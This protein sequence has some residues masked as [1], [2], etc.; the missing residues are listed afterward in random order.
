MG[1]WSPGVGP[2]G[3]GDT[4]TGDELVDVAD[5]GDGDDV[6][7]GFGGADT[8]NGGNGNDTLYGHSA[9]ATNTI[10][11]SVFVSGLNTPV[12]AT[13]TP[14]DPGFL[15]VMEKGTGVIWRIDTAS[16]ARTTFLDIPQSEFTSDGERGALG[17]AF[18]PD[19]ATNGRFF[20]YLTD[21]QGDIQIR[22]YSRSG[23]PAVANTSWSLVTEI[24]RNPA[25]NNHN[26]G[27]IG[28]SPEDG[29]LYFAT[30]DGGGAGDPNNNAQNLDSLLGKLIRIDVD[31][32]DQFPSDPNRNYG[33]PG[34][35]PFVG[36]AGADEI[37][38]Y[39]LRNPWRITFD[40]RNGDI[41]IADVGQSAREEIDYLANGQGG[42]NFGWRIMEGN[43]PY[44]PGGPGTPQPGD[45]ILRPPVFDYPRT[46][47]TTVTGGEVYTGSNAGFVGQ[48]VF[49]DFG[50]N[51]FFTLSVVNGAAVDPTDRTSQMTG[52]LPSSVVDFVTGTDGRLY[53]I[54]I[55][56]TVWLLTPGVGAEDVADTL[57]GGAGN[58]L[59]VG[60][61][62]NDILNG[63]ADVDTARYAISSSSAS[64]HR[65]QDGSWTVTAGAEGTDTVT[66]VE[67]LD[68]TDRDVFLGSAART[69]TGDGASDLLLQNVNGGLSLWYV[70]QNGA[71]VQYANGLPTAPGWTVEGTGDL[72]G[73]G[74]DDIVFRNGA[75]G[76]MSLWQMNG[77]AISP[78]SL[79]N[80]G[81]AWSVAGIGDL[82]GDT[83]DD[84]VWRNSNGDL[85]IWFM[86]G[87]VVSGASLGNV[88]SNWVIEALGDFNGD[89]RDDMLW[90]NNSTGAASIW[91]M[92]GAAVTA[93]GFASV[94]A[95]WQVA[96][97][98][99]FNGDGRD[100]IF[101]RNASTGDV[102][103]WMMN[104][105]S[106]TSAAGFG[107]STA[108]QQEGV[109][110]YNADGRDD[111]LWRNSATGDIV[112]WY[113]NGGVI[114]GQLYVG[115]LTPDWLINPGG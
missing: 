3:G 30:G 36:V 2:T 111:L 57:N 11:S 14:A 12:A 82:N 9:G 63:G 66:G 103:L 18:H 43:L 65:N 108:W 93:A 1:T 95:P 98:G 78:A 39:G 27:W 113:M 97:T 75:T 77:Q 55:G 8:L 34:D 22:E 16:G 10:V 52:A 53:A 44:N 35:N 90:R 28:F 67:Y 94:G 85:N 86:N 62:G 6:L 81:A 100:D 106:I 21:A 71:S 115:N 13:S 68:F 60:G 109:G 29:Y 59:L 105:S 40:Q 26:G 56:G 91:F 4:Y 99:D 88:S 87:A 32:S 49:A 107:L 92:N 84:I 61:A 64:W 114:S 69:F 58:D 74:R 41:Y 25:N 46:V 47:G 104:G 83:R 23:N 70:N 112:A 20:V 17:L 24:A 7:S 73:D 45:P 110:D 89:G 48:Y 38:A 37:W 79:G 42:V 15:Y 76:D 51:R 33:V 72:N 50:S 102:S 54:G 101:W 31:V 80:V 96:G 19:Y 5:G